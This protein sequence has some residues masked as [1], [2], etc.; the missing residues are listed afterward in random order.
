[1]PL[2]RIFRYLPPSVLPRRPW[3]PW[4]RASG[5]PFAVHRGPRGPWGRASGPPLLSIEGRGGVPVPLSHLFTPSVPPPY[6]D[7]FHFVECALSV[8]YFV[9]SSRS[10]VI[11]TIVYFKNVHIFISRILCVSFQFRS[12][13]TRIFHSDFDSFTI[14]HRKMCF[15][16][17]AEKIG[18]LWLC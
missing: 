10:T 15:K 6:C 1:M 12:A 14:F 8:K 2:I 4:G 18:R 5:A 11:L 13:L 9:V 16:I 7:Y 17:K 3:G